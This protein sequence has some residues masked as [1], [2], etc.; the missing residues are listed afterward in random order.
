MYREIVGRA[1]ERKMH[2]ARI[3]DFKRKVIRLR[4]ILV[5]IKL[6]F[7]QARKG[8]IIFSKGLGKNSIKLFCQP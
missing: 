6:T 3:E 8:N 5:D 1:M 7:K 4:A 2:E